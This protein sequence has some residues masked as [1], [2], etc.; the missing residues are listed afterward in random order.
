MFYLRDSQAVQI[1]I[2][3]TQQWPDYLYRS[4]YLIAESLTEVAQQLLQ[5][6]TKRDQPYLQAAKS[7]KTSESSH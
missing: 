6:Y 3:E 5:K 7:A 1:L 4:Q 2:D